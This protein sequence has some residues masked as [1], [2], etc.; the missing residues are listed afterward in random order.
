MMTPCGWTRIDADYPPH[1]PGDLL[2]LGANGVGVDGGRDELGVAEPFLHQVEGDGD[3]GAPEGMPQPL[4]PTP[5][6]S[7]SS[8]IF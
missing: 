6:S 1:P 7:D 4:I 3:G 5:Y 8:M 2:L